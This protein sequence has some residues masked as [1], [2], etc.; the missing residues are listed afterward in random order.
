MEPANQ[1]ISVSVWMITYNQAPYIAEAIEG[2]LMQE[3][4]FPVELVIGEDGSGDGTRAIILDYCDRYPGRIRLLPDEGNLGMMRNA[5]RTLRACRGKY[6]AMC[7]GDDYWVDKRK[8]QKQ[9][10][11]M[12]ANPD[13]SLCFHAARHAFPEGERDFVQRPFTGDAWIGL[14]T[15]VRG[16]GTMIPTASMFFQGKWTSAL[17]S[18]FCN[19]EVGD[20]PL[21]ILLALNGRVR[22]LDEAMC[23]Y[24]REVAGSWS[25][26]WS[27]RKMR[28]LSR[29]NNKMLM[30]INAQTR[31]RH[32]GV[33]A[34]KILLVNL[35]LLKAMVYVPLRPVYHFLRRARG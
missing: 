29:S 27:F 31:G 8:L 18:W 21:C 26:G 4:A 7:E 9:F 25:W 28:R 35:E 34:E 23:V 6:V 10:D 33:I 19:A 13:C 11:F 32:G 14:R 1:D 30:A 3:T 5:V 15:V 2:V 20:Y 16:G 22:Y 24:R 17:P 12:E